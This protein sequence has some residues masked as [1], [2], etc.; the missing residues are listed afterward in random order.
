MVNVSSLYAAA[1]VERVLRRTDLDIP[2]CDKGIGWLIASTA[3][4]KLIDGVRVEPQPLWPD[5]RGHFIEVLR[6]GHGLAADYPAETS[7]VSATLTHPGVV[8][9]FHYHLHQYDCWTV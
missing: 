3:S 6:V 1:P 2:Q 7:Q 5:D 4:D 8:K 9:A